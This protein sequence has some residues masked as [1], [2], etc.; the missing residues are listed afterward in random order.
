[1]QRTESLCS[2]SIRIRRGNLGFFSGVQTLNSR[3][4]SKKRQT[5]N[6]FYIVSA[7]C[8]IVKERNQK[9]HANAPYNTGYYSENY[10]QHIIRA[11]RP[12]RWSGAVD[13]ACA[14][15]NQ[16]YLSRA[17]IHCGN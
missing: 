2:G 15:V 10:I 11:G 9:R 13:N 1:M 16:T 8:S 12:Q 17:H 4:Y 7:L 3:Y 6:S 5:N 14:F